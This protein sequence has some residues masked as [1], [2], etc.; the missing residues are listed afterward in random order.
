[1]NTKF[2][3]TRSATGSKPCWKILQT[4]FKGKKKE[5]DH[6][7]ENDKQIGLLPILLL[8]LSHKTRQPQR[9]SLQAIP[10]TAL[11]SRLQNLF[12]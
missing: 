12:Y 3:P 4:L 10:I 7:A 8:R 6:E 9:A 11:Y 1:V 2:I 5:V